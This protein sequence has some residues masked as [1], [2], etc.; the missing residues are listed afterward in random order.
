MQLKFFHDV[1]CIIFIIE[2]LLL[3]PFINNFFG[4]ILTY[5]TNHDIL[6]HKSHWTCRLIANLLQKWLVITVRP[7]TSVRK[8]P[9]KKLPPRNTPDSFCRRLTPTKSIAALRGRYFS[10]WETY[11]ENFISRPNVILTFRQRRCT[12]RGRNFVRSK[13][14]PHYMSRT[15]STYFLRLNNLETFVELVGPRPLQPAGARPIGHFKAPLGLSVLRK[16][17]LD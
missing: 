3:S 2:V 11:L 15:P 13:R 4:I 12:N 10:L 16:R 1:K 7:T 5:L 17:E 6:Y 14:W 8:N 9:R